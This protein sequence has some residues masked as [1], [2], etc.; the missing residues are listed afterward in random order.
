MESLRWTE[1]RD[2]NIKLVHEAFDRLCRT[3]GRLNQVF[4][5]FCLFFFV[6]GISLIIYFSYQII[7]CWMHERGDYR[8]TLIFWLLIWVSWLA[9]II[10]SAD[11]P[12]HQVTVCFIAESRSMSIL[13]RWI[14]VRKLRQRLMK[15]SHRDLVES[16][17]N[18]V[19]PSFT[20]MLP[21]VS[22]ERE[23][24]NENDFHFEPVDNWAL[25]I[26]VVRLFHAS[27]RRLR[28]SDGWW[29]LQRRNASPSQC[30]SVWS[31]PTNKS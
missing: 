21:S 24:E 23:P 8:E 28:W 18:Q 17:K 4:S 9:V 1:N 6:D 11:L 3:V 15:L 14:Q 22:S 31:L 2:V 29:R 5:I 12:K 25:L 26:T 13:I 7:Y 20:T 27:D 19:L 10:H 30:E 16:E